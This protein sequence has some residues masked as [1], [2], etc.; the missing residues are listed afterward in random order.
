ML[1]YILFFVL[2]IYVLQKK[3]IIEGITRPCCSDSLLN[4]SSELVNETCVDQETPKP[5]ARCFRKN[6]RGDDWSCDNCGEMCP[7]LSETKCYP[8]LV[9]D[10]DDNFKDGGYCGNPNC[11]NKSESECTSGKNCKWESNRCKSLKKVYKGSEA[12]DLETDIG[13]DFNL[14]S[15][16]YNEYKDYI[17]DKCNPFASLPDRSEDQDFKDFEEDLETDIQIKKENTYQKE[18]SIESYGLLSDY[19]NMF[20]FVTFENFVLF[21]AIL[22]L[23]SIIGSVIYFGKDEF[24]YWFKMFELNWFRKKINKKN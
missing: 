24:R 1:R 12:G 16:A 3:Q 21:L 7:G 20:Y 5:I 13:Q 15:R 18:E 19:D 22:S 9:K 10:E 8:T 14:N 6:D 23:L 11:S 2:F 17:K 4:F